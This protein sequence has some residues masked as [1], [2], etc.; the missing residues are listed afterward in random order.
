MNALT[1]SF[2]RL[3]TMRRRI[4][5]KQIKPINVD[6]AQQLV[7]TAAPSS[8]SLT[9]PRPAHFHQ[10]PSS[11]TPPHSPFQLAEHH[12]PPTAPLKSPLRRAFSK[13]F[14]FGGGSSSNSSKES[15]SRSSTP[16]QISAPLIDFQSFNASSDSFGTNSPRPSASCRRSLLPPLPIY[17]SKNDPAPP[18]APRRRPASASSRVRSFWGS[19]VS[20]EAGATA[21]R[22]SSLRQ[23]SLRSIRQLHHRAMSSWA[24]PSTPEPVEPLTNPRP[25]PSP[26][27]EAQPRRLLRR[28]SEESFFCRGLGHDGFDDSDLPELPHMAPLPGLAARRMSNF[29]K[30]AYGPFDVEISTSTG[31]SLLPGDCSGCLS[32][33]GLGFTDCSPGAPRPKPKRL[34]IA[35]Q[36]S[37]ATSLGGESFYSSSSLHS[38]TNDTTSSPRASWPE[39]ST[40][41]FS[42][43]PPTPPSAIRL[44]LQFLSLPRVTG[45][46]NTE[47]PL[48]DDNGQPFDALF[49]SSN[50]SVLDLKELVAARLRSK[51][52][53]VFPRELSISLNLADSLY[54]H[55]LTCQTWASSS[56]ALGLAFNEDGCSPIKHLS[57]NSRLLFEEGAQEDDTMIV[58]YLPHEV[59]TKFF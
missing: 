55:S 31:H 52:Y 16:L 42:S 12:A 40:Q 27:A 4:S 38:H 32:L 25:P 43:C 44:K 45:K 30:D 9:T 26:F 18:K 35:S 8:S 17:E 37:E 56:S 1:T 48:L 36:M 59:L 39:V 46:L 15:H 5:K 10:V 3:P 11:W 19:D 47:S 53:R 20:T 23:N 22:A 2:G 51:G 34:S 50:N 24:A 33:A 41:W 21:T 6:A 58:R 14:F 54:Q 7:Q 57:N 28:A 13:P 29:T 49:V